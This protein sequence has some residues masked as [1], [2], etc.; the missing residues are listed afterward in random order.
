MKLSL[1]SVAALSLLSALIAPA[2]LAGS[3]SAKPAGMDRNYVG[4]G[5]AA[6]VTNGGQD[7]DAANLGGN[8]QGRFEVPNAPVSVRG[9]ILFSDDTS[10]IMPIISYDVPVTNNA[11]VYAG[12]G[13][14]FVEANGE[15]SPLGNDD[16]VVL[17]TGVEAGVTKDIVVYGD[18]KWGINAYEDSEA[19]A[20]SFQLGAGYRF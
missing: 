3:A 8:I 15:P 10:A 9:A 20:L 13:Y 4:A 6:G 1:K 14:S 18:A 11:N 5:L 7:G 16:S 19:D 17:T 12:V 2:F